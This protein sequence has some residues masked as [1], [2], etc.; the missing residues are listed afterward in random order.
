VERF[1]QNTLSRI[2]NKLPNSTPTLGLRIMWKRKR[3]TLVRY[4]A[5]RTKKMS[6]FC[7]MLAMSHTTHIA[8]DSIEFHTDTG[9]V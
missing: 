6:Y 4:V 3:A 9:F 8:S 2:R 5:R 1:Y 7:V